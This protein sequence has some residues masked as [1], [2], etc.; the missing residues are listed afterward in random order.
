MVESPR[1]WVN[2]TA[3]ASFLPEAVAEQSDAILPR[4]STGAFIRASAIAPIRS[5]FIDKPFAVSFGTRGRWSALRKGTDSP[6]ERLLLRYA[7]PWR[8]LGGKEPYGCDCFADGA[9]AD[10]ARLFWYG[11]TVWK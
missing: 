6:D 5:R 8:S 4:L 7:E 11:F 2:I 3:S 9:R 10:P 1:S